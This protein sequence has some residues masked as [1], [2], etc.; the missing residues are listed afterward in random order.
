M[1]G[2]GRGSGCSPAPSFSRLYFTLNVLSAVE[3]NVAGTHA[4][5]VLLAKKDGKGDPACYPAGALA[6]D[7]LRA[8]EA[9]QAALLKEDPTAVRA[10]ADGRP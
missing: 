10:W 8:L 9:H 5:Q 3:A 4:Y 2:S 6:E 7:A 1:I